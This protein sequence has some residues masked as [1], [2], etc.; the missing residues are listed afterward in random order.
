MNSDILYKFV[1]ESNKIEGIHG[2]MVREIEA[3][4]KLLELSILTVRDIEKFVSEIDPTIKLRDK[5]GMNVRVGNYYPSQGGDNIRTELG[6]ILALII[7][8]PTMNDS[9]ETHVEYEKLHPFM[10]VNGRSGRA[11]WAWQMKQE[12]K[13]PYAIPFLH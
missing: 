4:E 7:S 9:Y 11:I 8:T 10:D 6:T 2:I 5:P 12:G 3:H 13:D 1:R